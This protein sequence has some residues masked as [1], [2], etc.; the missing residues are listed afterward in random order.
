[1][2]GNNEQYHPVDWKQYVDLRFES[3]QRA[4]D[5]LAEVMKAKMENLNEWKEQSRDQTATHPTRIE[6]ENRFVNIEKEI[7]ILQLTGAKMEGMATQKS[8]NT[9]T[10]IAVVGFL[11]GLVSIML[12]YME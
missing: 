1:M 5:V 7:K 2:E 4:T 11:I 10:I 3:M 12:N 8:V 9:S 6:T